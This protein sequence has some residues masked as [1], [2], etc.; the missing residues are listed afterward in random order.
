[1]SQ[2]RFIGFCLWHNQAERGEWENGE[3]FAAIQHV[4]TLLGSC[5]QVKERF[6]ALIC[7][8]AP[9]EFGSR[10]RRLRFWVRMSA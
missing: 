6:Q 4:D 5:L 1:M 10:V 8:G 9:H 3:E 2:A 7:I